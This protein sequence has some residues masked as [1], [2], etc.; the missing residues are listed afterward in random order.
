MGRDPQTGE[1]IV[2]D[3]MLTPDSSRYWIAGSYEVR[4]GGG[5]EVGDGGASEGCS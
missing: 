4:A 2:I 1:I 3:E 5:R